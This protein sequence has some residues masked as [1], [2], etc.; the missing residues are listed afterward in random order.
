M[1]YGNGS[2]NEVND[3]LA[4]PDQCALDAPLM[5][6]LLVNTIRVYTVDNTES[7]DACMKSFSEHGIYVIISLHTPENNI[8]SVR[9]QSLQRSQS[10]A[11]AWI[12][13]CSFDVLLC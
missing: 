8:N 12:P 10:G 6:T 13:F 4:D 1:V 5:Q 9:L 2:P 11:I 3:P 7:H